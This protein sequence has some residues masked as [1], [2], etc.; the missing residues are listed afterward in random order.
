MTAHRLV[1][2]PRVAADTVLTRQL[3]RITSDRNCLEHD[4]RIEVL[5]AAVEQWKDY[6]HQDAD[7]SAERQAEKAHDDMCESYLRHA[8]Q[9][10]ST[11]QR[12]YHQVG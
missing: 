2:D 5:S 1:V 10:R 7:A 6:L 11:G 3:T 12:T 8:R 4:D 9:Q